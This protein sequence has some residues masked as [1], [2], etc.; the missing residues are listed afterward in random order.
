M[1]NIS[2]EAKTAIEILE[3]NNHKA[4]LAGGCVRDLIMG[5]VPHDWDIASSAEPGETREIFEK[6]GFR[7]ICTGI[8]HGTVTVVIN[9]T[10]LEITTFRR[11]SGYSDHRRPDS[12]EFVK[13]PQE[14]VKRRDFTVNG[15]LYNPS[16][17][18]L[19]FTDGISDINKGVIRCIG[20]PD[21]RFSED[22][23]RIMRAMRFASVLGFT[24]DKE[25]SDSMI[26]NRNLLNEISQERKASELTKLLLGKDVKFILYEYST[27]L[28]AVIPEIRYMIGFDQNNPHHCYDVWIHTIEA[29]AAVPPDPVLRLTM[30]LHDI[31]KPA[32][33]T[34]DSYGIYH[35]YNHPGKSAAMARNILSYLKYPGDI[36][37]KV[38]TLITYHDFRFP[39][40]R[41]NVKKLLNRI[42]EDN[43][44]KLLEVRRADI[45][46]QDPHYT[47]EKFELLEET[48]R[49]LDKVIEENQCFTLRDLKINGRDLLDTGFA[50]GRQLGYV[51]DTLLTMVIN[52]EL[53]NDREILLENAQKMMK[54]AD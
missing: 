37:E 7:T 25:T 4:Y 51:L 17:G 11:D 2:A 23:L 34:M 32:S 13:T 30:L 42:G 18:I 36:I 9:R 10:N 12:V 41:K 38:C 47:K 1:F 49:V 6:A 27:V 50:Q 24:I 44:R 26:R 39:P 8:S 52:E 19:D 29:V 45:S 28:A 43:F 35:F 20:D 16:E 5:K 31:G 54:R 15:I 22:A 46:A 33:C 48:G 40:D 53:P 3:S 14:D 21:E